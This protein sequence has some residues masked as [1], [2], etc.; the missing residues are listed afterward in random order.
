MYVYPVFRGDD[1]SALQF[2]QFDAYSEAIGHM[3]HE[4][5][6]QYFNAEKFLNIKKT[7]NKPKK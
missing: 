4:A 3:V 2:V 7:K 1:N 5:V 6:T